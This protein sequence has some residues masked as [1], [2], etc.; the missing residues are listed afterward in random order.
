MSVL[1]G[2]NSAKKVCRK[3]KK[4]GF[5]DTRSR[6]PRSYGS[7]IIILRSTQVQGHQR[8]LT[9]FRVDPRHQTTSVCPPHHNH[10]RE[11]LPGPPPHSFERKKKGDCRTLK[12]EA[13]GVFATVPWRP[14]P[15]IRRAACVCRP[16]ALRANVLLLLLLLLLFCIPLHRRGEKC[17]VEYLLCSINIP[18]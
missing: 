6:S 13:R 7:M 16:Q 8:S 1:S 14:I 15:P 9:S 3:I 18:S 10:T 4:T 17:P 2:T 5:V 11:N 12:A